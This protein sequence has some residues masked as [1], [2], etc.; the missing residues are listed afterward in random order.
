MK[1]RQIKKIQKIYPTRLIEV[2]VNGVKLKRNKEFTESAKDNTLTIIGEP[3][4]KKDILTVMYR[5][6]G[7]NK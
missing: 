4:G 5:P 3:L 1:K 2:R 7:V 6:G